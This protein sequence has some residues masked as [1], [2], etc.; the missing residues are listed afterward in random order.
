MHSWSKSGDVVHSWIALFVCATTRAVHLEVVDSLSTESFLIAFRKFVAR[1]SLPSRIRSDNATAF[2]AASDKLSVPWMFNPP[3]EPWHGGS[4]ERMVGTVKSALKKVMGTAFLK[5]QELETLLYEV[6]AV[7]NSRPLTYVSDSL[8]EPPVTP[9][10]MMGNIWMSSEKPAG[11]LDAAQMSSR[12]R[13]LSRTLEH[14]KN[15]WEVEYLSQLNKHQ[16]TMS[17]PLAVGDVVFVLDDTKRKQ[18]WRLGRIMELFPGR[19]GK[20]RVA[21]VK[22]SNS[23]LLRPIQRLVPLEVSSQDVAPGLADTAQPAIVPQ[24]QAP[25]P[26]PR[27]QEMTRSGRVVRAPDRF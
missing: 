6:E 22:L 12:L 20:R 1:R 11:T 10:M 4:Y 14:V 26:P 7:V 24:H 25:L 2:K 3:A 18:F 16:Q 27:Q 13:Y 19:D 15:R 8:D 23:T 5:V 9:A 21:K 17:R